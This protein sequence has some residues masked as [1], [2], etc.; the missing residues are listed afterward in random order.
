MGMQE[1]IQKIFDML[2]K[3]KRPTSIP[4]PFSKEPIKIGIVYDTVMALKEEVFTNDKEI[5][6]LKMGDYALPLKDSLFQVKKIDL[7]TKEKIKEFFETHEEYS[8]WD[9]GRLNSLIKESLEQVAKERSLFKTI[10]DFFR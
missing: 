8:N 4:Q 2:I 6:S 1:I 9:L 3:E 5:T 10:A 7:K